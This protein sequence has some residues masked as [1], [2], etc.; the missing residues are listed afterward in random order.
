L[1]SGPRQPHEL[2]KLGGQE[3]RRRE[4]IESARE[5]AK[6]SGQKRHRSHPAQVLAHGRVDSQLVE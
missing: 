2:T 4:H 6:G 5:Q 1:G 3:S